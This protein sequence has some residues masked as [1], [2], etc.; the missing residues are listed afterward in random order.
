MF[1]DEG[2]GF[3]AF[4]SLHIHSYSTL[5]LSNTLSGERLSGSGELPLRLSG[6]YTTKK[7]CCLSNSWFS[8]YCH[9]HYSPGQQDDQDCEGDDPPYWERAVCGW[10]RERRGWF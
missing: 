1:S 7:E 8:S 2:M 10:R 4:C 3:V 9:Q 5:L 6:K